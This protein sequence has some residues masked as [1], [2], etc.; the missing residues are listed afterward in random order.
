MRAIRGMMLESNVE[1]GKQDFIY[2][3]TRKEDLNPFVSIT[4]PCI[5]WKE[6][7]ALILM[8]HEQFSI[9]D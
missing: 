8:A 5:G 3:Q 2:G 4:D 6:T 1:E 7:E 9:A